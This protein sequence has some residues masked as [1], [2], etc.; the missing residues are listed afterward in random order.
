MIVNPFQIQSMLPDSSSISLES[1]ATGCALYSRPRRLAT[2]FARSRSKPVYSPLS[3][4]NP[5][6]GKSWSKPTISVPPAASA[7]SA[8]VVSAVVVSVFAP[9]HAARE[10]TIADAI[11]ALNNLFFIIISSSYLS[12]I[13]LPGPAFCH[14]RKP[15][16]FF[17]PVSPLCF[18]RVIML[19]Y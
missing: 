5:I 14:I 18:H 16:A 15:A 9:P 7:V 2:S 8:A 1:Q 6:G 10:S 4:T 19:P 12:L 3:P 17:C 13:R 11:T